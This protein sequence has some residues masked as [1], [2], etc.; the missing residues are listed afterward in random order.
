LKEIMKTHLIADSVRYPT[1]TTAQIR[2]AFLIDALYEPGALNLAY[3]DLDR[4]V[5]GMAAP[6]RCPLTRRCARIT[7][8]N[9]VSWGR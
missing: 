4:A 1:M 5:V 3:V 6:S 8:Q 7:S 9:V 2:D